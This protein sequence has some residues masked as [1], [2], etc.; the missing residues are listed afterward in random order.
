MTKTVSYEDFNIY[1]ELVERR[2]RKE[3]TEV[4]QKAYHNKLREL[5]RSAFS[6]PE[7]VENHA[8]LMA[9]EAE[10][11]QLE[12]PDRNVFGLGIGVRVLFNHSSAIDPMR[13]TFQ[14][15]D[16]PGLEDAPHVVEVEVPVGDPVPGLIL[17]KG[18]FR[19]DRNMSG[20]CTGL[21][22]DPRVDETVQL[23][24]E[25]DPEKNILLGWYGKPDAKYLPHYIA[26]ITDAG[27]A[28]WT[29]PPN[30]RY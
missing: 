17:P 29:Q 12:R 20:I 6:N 11:A 26:E 30:V 21:G 7:E 25:V 28:H 3:A 14:P 15:I 4:G 27:G 2:R 8:R 19:V 23:F 16:D 24:T 18:T 1:S 10:A 22:A 5:G 9:N 13:R